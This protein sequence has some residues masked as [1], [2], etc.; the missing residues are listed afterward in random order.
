[1][2][3][4]ETSSNVSVGKLLFNKFPIQNGLKQGYALQILSDDANK[5]E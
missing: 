3:L 5:S 1:M 2:C 4:S